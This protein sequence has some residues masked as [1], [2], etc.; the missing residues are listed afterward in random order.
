MVNSNIEPEFIGIDK[1]KNGIVT[2]RVRWDI[3]S[4]QKPDDQGN[5]F[6]SWTYEECRL[7]WVLPQV[8]ETLSDV[9]AYLDE[10]YSAGEKILDWA[11]ASKI[12]I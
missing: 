7:E 4:E 5:L 12:S 2:I 3:S 9:K 6:T 8:Y 1:V 11:Q 10:N